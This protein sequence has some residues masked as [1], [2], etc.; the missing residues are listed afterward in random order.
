MNS[1][2]NLSRAALLFAIFCCNGCGRSDMPELGEV[3]GT[4][5]MDSKPLENAQVSFHTEKEKGGRP[6]T[7]ITDKE[8][9]YKLGFVASESGAIVGPNRVEITTFWP[10]G[11]PGEGQRE[12][13]PEK[14]N[15]K[16]TLKREVKSGSNTFD[17][18]L[19]SK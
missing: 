9:K 8:G 11:E 6:G 18:E 7:G 1:M 2:G 5:T 19:E 12:T 10:D 13:I 17:F 15:S 3:Q 4:V 14:Y 16:S